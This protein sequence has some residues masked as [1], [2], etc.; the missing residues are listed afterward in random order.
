MI[1]ID[2]TSAPGGPGNVAGVIKVGEVAVQARSLFTCG[3]AWWMA[4]TS[5]F[6]PSVPRHR[7][8]QPST[9]R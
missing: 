9:L 6:S 8:M 7:L 5:R 2:L 1:I 3:L 4:T